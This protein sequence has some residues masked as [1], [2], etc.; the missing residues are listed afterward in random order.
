[1]S[2][3][4]LRMSLTVSIDVDSGVYLLTICSMS[5]VNLCSITSAVG[6]TALGIRDRVSIFFVSLEE[7]SSLSA[8]NFI[9]GEFLI[10]IISIS[11]FVVLFLAV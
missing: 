4:S 8:Q 6:A 5:D 1:M 11:I 9:L 10:W 7:I 2:P 3:R